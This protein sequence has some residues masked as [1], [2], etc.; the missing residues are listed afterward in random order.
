MKAGRELDALV[1]EKVMS[2]EPSKDGGYHRKN[3]NDTFQITPH[4]STDIA[5]AWKVVEALAQSP[6]WIAVTVSN[7]GIPHVKM[8]R[9]GNPVS[10]V[11]INLDNIPDSRSYSE[12][13]AGAICLAALEAIQS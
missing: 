13:C 2:M 12:R 11:W 10:E 6:H 8:Y 7:F 4:Y 5:A 3:R 1:T 9:N